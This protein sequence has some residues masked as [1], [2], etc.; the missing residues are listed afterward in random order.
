MLQAPSKDLTV[1]SVVG[2]IRTINP[3]KVSSSDVVAKFIA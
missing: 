3:A 2:R 1:W